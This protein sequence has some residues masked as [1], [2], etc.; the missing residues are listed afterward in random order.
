[1]RKNTISKLAL[2]T[3]LLMIN[4]S[5]KGFYQ[6]VPKKDWLI[7][8]IQNNQRKIWIKVIDLQITSPLDKFKGFLEPGYYR[9]K[10][11]GAGGKEEVKEFTLIKTEEFKACVGAVVNHSFN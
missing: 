11:A 3:G 4:T 1:M 10:A 5:T 9:V 8:F 6:C 2:L 7:N